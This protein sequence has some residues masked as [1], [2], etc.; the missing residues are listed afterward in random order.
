MLGGLHG[1]DGDGSE[2]G[3][4]SDSESDEQEEQQVTDAAAGAE[5][6]MRGLDGGD[7]DG[8]G[9]S[10]GSAAD[11]LDDEARADEA[12]FHQ[13]AQWL[14]ATQTPP[15]LIQAFVAGEDGVAPEAVLPD[16]PPHI[17]AAAARARFVRTRATRS[18]YGTSAA[19]IGRLGVSA[20][21]GDVDGIAVALQWTDANRKSD[22]DG[23]TA[24]WLAAEAGHSEA[25]RFLAAHGAALDEPADMEAFHHGGWGRGGLSAACRCTPLYAAA[26]RG[27]E[28]C[29]D[30]LLL[31]GADPNTPD[32]LGRTPLSAA[33]KGG[34][35][36]VVRRLAKHN[37]T[38]HRNE[39]L[40]RFFGGSAQ[41]PSCPAIEIDRPT[42]I[43]RTPLFMAAEA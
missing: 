31:L 11:P 38:R 15:H 1:S 2:S 42:V 16:A 4:E 28:A 22:F 26:R 25:V 39:V 14:H 20:A 29:V 18:N 19:G 12:L 30:A 43:G 24:L 7:H 21:A 36:G 13:L 41:A 23:R 34:H 35:V 3:S 33:C 8:D 6:T 27:H 40:A 9:S 37:D 10:D 32:E 5:S 17:I